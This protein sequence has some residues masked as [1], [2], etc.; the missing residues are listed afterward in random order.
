MG[1]LVHNIHH[2]DVPLGM[3]LSLFTMIATYIDQKRKKQGRLGGI[4]LSR[5]AIVTVIVIGA[6]CW[7]LVGISIA[8]LYV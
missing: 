6:I 2:F 1:W 7:T 5:A 3:S 8:R 4:T